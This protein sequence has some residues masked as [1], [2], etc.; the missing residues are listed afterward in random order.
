MQNLPIKEFGNVAYRIHNSSGGYGFT[1]GQL[2]SRLVN[3]LIGALQVETDSSNTHLLLGN[4]NFRSL[5][6]FFTVKLY[7]F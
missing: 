6:K 1:F 4:M 7:L 2:K 3:L 5:F